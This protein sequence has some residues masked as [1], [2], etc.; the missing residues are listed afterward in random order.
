MYEANIHLVS[1]LVGIHK[2]YIYVLFIYTEFQKLLSITSN[3]L[4]HTEVQKK[5]FGITLVQY[6]IY[7]YC[8]ITLSSYIEFK[9]A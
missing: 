7:L 1:V 9:L 4:C 5:L 6:L 2:A 8:Y 3:L